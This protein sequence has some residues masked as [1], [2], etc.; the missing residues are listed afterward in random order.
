MMVPMM[1]ILV[2][3]SALCIGAFEH[4]ESETVCKDGTCADEQ[5]FMRLHA[6]NTDH[7]ATFAWLNAMDE[8]EN[9]NDPDYVNTLIQPTPTFSTGGALAA[10]V[11]TAA[12]TSPCICGGN[13][14]DTN[15]ACTVAN[16]ACVPATCTNTDGSA[17]PANG[18]PCKCPSTAGVY[19]EEGEGCNVPSN[20]AGYC[21]PIA[22]A[23]TGVVADGAPP[24][25]CGASGSPFAICETNEACT[26]SGTKCHLAMCAAPQLKTTA[27]GSDLQTLYTWATAVGAAD[28]GKKCACGAVAS[29]STLLTNQLGHAVCQA[30]QWCFAA[31][32]SCAYRPCEQVDG[33][34]KYIPCVCEHRICDQEDDR[35][36]LSA[37][38]SPNSCSRT[39]GLS[40][41]TAACSVT[42]GTS[43]GSS[44]LYGSSAAA[45]ACKC[46]FNLCPAMKLGTSSSPSATLANKAF[47]FI[48]DHSCTYTACGVTTLSGSDL[49]AQTH[50]PCSCSHAGDLSAGTLN[51]FCQEGEYCVAA[52]AGA[53]TCQ[54]PPCASGNNL[55]PCQCGKAV[56]MDKETCTSGAHQCVVPACANLATA[57]GIPGGVA[58]NGVDYPAVRRCKCGDALC[59][60][61][62]NC[63]AASHKCT[64]PNCVD[65]N[66]AQLTSL[67]CTCSWGSGTTA[68]STVC[69]GRDR[70]KA[71]DQVCAPLCTNTDGS[72][73]NANT[74][75]C[76]VSLTKCDAG[77]KCTVATA[78]N[79]LTTDTCLGDCH[80]ADNA[81]AATAACACGSSICSTGQLCSA[82]TSTCAAA[83]TSF[84]G[85]TM[86]A[87]SCFCGT[88]LCTA[89]QYCGCNT[90]P[91]T[92]GTCGATAGVGQSTSAVCK[93]ADIAGGLNNAGGG[94]T[95]VFP[96]TFQNIV[97]NTCTDREWD[98][99]WC[100]T[101][102]GSAMWGNCAANCKTVSSACR[103]VAGNPDSRSGYAGAGKVCKFPFT[104]KGTTYNSCIKPDGSNTPWCSMVSDFNEGN[105][106]GF[107]GSDCPRP[108][109]HASTGCLTTGSAGAGPGKPCVFP[110][111]YGKQEY[112]KCTDEDWNQ[113]WCS[114]KAAPF[115][116]IKEWGAC[117][118]TKCPIQAKPVKKLGIC[119]PGNAKVLSRS[120]PKD[121]AHVRLGDEIL[122]FNAATGKD[123]FTKVDA[124]L[125]R[126]TNVQATFTKLR[127]GAGDILASPG[128]NLAV[129]HPDRYMFA[130]DI[131]VGATLITT[132]GTASV[133]SSSW[134]D[135]EGF[136]APWT[137]TSNF[138]I[139]VDQD[140]FLVHSLAN[141]N[142]RF[143]ILL[144]AV[145]K[146]V[147]LFVPSLHHFD[148]TTVTDYLHPV[149]RIFWSLVEVPRL[150]V[151]EGKTDSIEAN[152]RHPIGSIVASVAG[153]PSDN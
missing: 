34:E 108:A 149:A 133:T 129:G 81:T 37:S 96:F 16:S 40:A 88:T 137:A 29:S 9:G 20:N 140:F 59:D 43:A 123:E 49:Q 106:W 73:A 95:C 110:F 151:K 36:V 91:C 69:V 26:A 122:G 79:G 65:T 83:C 86:T 90:S 128:H 28:F 121:M 41:E 101:Q 114:T 57:S 125:H 135:G 71:S 104:Y 45:P 30:N 118:T 13:I 11:G 6:E 77:M 144:G 131:P 74:C 98:R 107:C 127:T 31:K 60:V 78:T 145:F 150:L 75:L 64:Y 51:P 50:Y 136:Y 54:I 48:A 113:P 25:R 19:C 12:Q 52:S 94:K 32:R 82:T 119:F 148:E 70:C 124:W 120:G 93:T 103:T 21:E 33:V 134:E 84:T 68:G 89:G 112:N 47:C 109:L 39:G 97:Y 138:Y 76:G 132:N 5:S 22:C 24:C 63:V 15:E 44:N 142:S 111:T 99:P 146:V 87:T 92:A 4:S 152:W 115:D 117:D 147:Q 61:G 35:C 141:I 105:D 66:G 58:T 100:P 130:N 53:G 8:E 42:P 38:G 85:H 62:Q 46:G 27:I 126:V 55:F 2:A 102:P 3:N 7:E 72:A 14:C 23:S 116:F 1:M 18:Y 153:V 139:G 56:C 10:C 80:T 143:E 67:P 17:E